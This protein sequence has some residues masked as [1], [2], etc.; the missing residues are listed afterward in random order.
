MRFWS[1]G[2]GDRELV[3]CLGKAKI[4]RKGEMM[5]LSGVVSSPAPWEY[6]VLV[7]RADWKTILETAVSQAA[8]G[9]I[10]THSTLGLLARM[11]RSIVRFA[12]LLAWFRAIRLATAW[13]APAKSH[14]AKGLSAAPA[15]AAVEK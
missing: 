4:E 14:Q 10:A 5:L 15:P 9:Y 3:M 13:A 2:L 1:E 12:A 11:G 6:E 8:C 7:E